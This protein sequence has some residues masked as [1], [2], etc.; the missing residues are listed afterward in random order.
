MLPRRLPSVQ[1]LF[2]FVGPVAARMLALEVESLR[3]VL[4]TGEQP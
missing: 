1:I 4:L 2:G 3:T